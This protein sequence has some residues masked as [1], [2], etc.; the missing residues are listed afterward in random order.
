MLH[1]QLA[2]ADQLLARKNTARRV[3]RIRHQK[4]FRTGKF[5]VEIFEIDLE[6]PLHF[7]HRI[8]HHHSVI[9]AYLSRKRMVNRRLDHDPVPRR[10]ESTQCKNNPR[11]DTGCK[12]EPLPLDF[13]SA[14]TFDPADDGIPIL[15]AAIGIAQDRMFGPF[16]DRIQ[17]CRRRSEFHIGH[18]QRND[19]AAPVKPLPRIQLLAIRSLAGDYLVKIVFHRTRILSRSFHTMPACPPCPLRQNRMPRRLRSPAN[20]TTDKTERLSKVWN[21]RKIAIPLSTFT[22]KFE[23]SAGLLHLFNQ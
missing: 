9:E 13:P 20:Y 10:G 17:D 6:A 18:P 16:T 8:V 11:H 19:I 22:G 23:L 21:L 15:I 1:A 5:S 2:D 7:T 3:V 4:D 14:A 12:V